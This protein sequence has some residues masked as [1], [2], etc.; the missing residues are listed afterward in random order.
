MRNLNRVTGLLLCAIVASVAT[1]EPPPFAKRHAPDI[2]EM[3]ERDA[4][5]IG[6]DGET[7]ERIRAVVA[8]ARTEAEAVERELHEQREALHRLLSVDRPDEAA[9]MRQA[10]RIGALETDAL[11]HRLRTLLAVHPLLTDEQ[12]ARLREL[13]E[14]RIGAVFERCSEELAAFCPGVGP[15]PGRVRC[16]RRHDDR[17]SDPCREALRGL[18]RPRPQRVP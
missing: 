9:V 6:L 1:A 14:R 18:R 16:L 2:A 3:L 15:G 4:E 12:L 11:K 8:A 5:A 13:R 17:L 10:E 7:R